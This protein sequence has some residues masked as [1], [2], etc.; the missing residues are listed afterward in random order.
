MKKL[1]FPT[2]AALLTAVS[3]LH[4]QAVKEHVNSFKESVYT[5]KLT[6]SQSVSFT[7]DEQTTP[8]MH[9]VQYIDDENLL[10][11][12]FRDKLIFFDMQS[13]QQKQKVDIPSSSPAIFSYIN[14]DSI[15][16]NDGDMFVLFDMNGDVHSRHNIRYP[17]RNM[18]LP[19]AKISE[20]LLKDNNLYFTGNVTG[21]SPLENSRNRDVVMCYDLSSSKIRSTM[22][23][24]KIYQDHNWGGALFRWVYSAFDNQ[25]NIIV[26]LPAD[27]NIYIN[28]LEFTEIKEVYAGSS[29]F[30]STNYLDIPKMMPLSKGDF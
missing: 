11:M 18:S 6:S 13:G 7:F 29:F 23:Y 9:G 2:I 21:E 25:D 26:S 16:V 20:I 27:H 14:R 4:A 24:S 1:I 22:S 3:P 19:A 5:H 15:Y 28:D 12:R 8:Y 10:A 17:K 30:S